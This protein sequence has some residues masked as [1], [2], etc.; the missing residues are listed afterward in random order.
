ML[1]Y[2]VALQDQGL[3]LA[4]AGDVLEFR[5]VLDHAADLGGL[6][7]GRLK[8]LADPSL[9]GDRLAHIYY[10][11]E[12]VLVHVDSGAVGQFFKFFLN[13][14]HLLYLYRIFISDRRR[15][16]GRISP[17]RSCGSTAGACA[18]QPPDGL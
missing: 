17:D 8:I 4:A 12:S 18:P 5:D 13:V 14:E 3:H 9:E 16:S 6:I 2:Q 11:P 15:R 1:F 10:L 7:F